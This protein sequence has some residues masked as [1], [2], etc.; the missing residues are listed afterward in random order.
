MI[1]LDVL[2]DVVLFGLLAVGMWW[3]GTRSV[4][5]QEGRDT[6]SE[7]QEQAKESASASESGSAYEC[8]HCGEE[9]VQEDSYEHDGMSVEIHRCTS[10]DRPGAIVHHSDGSTSGSGCLAEQADQRIHTGRDCARALFGGIKR[11]SK[12]VY[13]LLKC[14]SGGLKSLVGRLRASDGHSHEKPCVGSLRCDH[15]ETRDGTVEECDDPACEKLHVAIVC[16]ECGSHLGWRDEPRD[17]RE[18]IL[19]GDRFEGPVGRVWRVADPWLPVDGDVFTPCILLEAQEDGGEWCVE[20]EI[21]ETWLEKGTF[22]PFDEEPIEQEDVAADGGTAGVDDFSTVL[23]R[24][25]TAFNSE[26]VLVQDADTK[27]LTY[28]DKHAEAVDAEALDYLREQEFEILQ[29]GRK[30]CA[31]TGEEHACVQSR[32][33]PGTRRNRGDRR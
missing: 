28:Y 31:S 9:V 5:S 24:L 14:L 33:D 20:C 13:G 23:N 7:K 22:S 3:S 29:S 26:C 15:E 10:C 32:R 4:P 30:E 16:V 18:V 2:F 17:E 27:H 21:F 11:L 6:S 19:S 25:Q 8:D 1:A 12:G